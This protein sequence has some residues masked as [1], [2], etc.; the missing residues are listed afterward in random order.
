MNC[1]MSIELDHWIEGSTPLLINV[2]HAGTHIPPAIAE[3]MNADA[4]RVPDTD[5]HVDTLYDFAASLGAS[6]MVATH[7]RYVVDLNRDPQGTALYPG[8]DNSE[9]VPLR[10]FDCEPIYRE[11]KAPD[12]DE[13]ARRR[14]V[15]WQPY[16][17]RLR[18]RIDDLRARHGH[19]VLLDA[20]SIRSQVPR[21]FD[22]KLPDLNLG[23]DS[24]LS[25]AARLAGRAMDVLSDTTLF[26]A[27][28]DGRFKGGYITR[29]YADPAGGVHCL[30]LEI[31]QAAYMN[32]DPPWAWSA[33]RAS[34]LQ[35]LLI[36]LIETLVQWRP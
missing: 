27:I 9:L 8:A 30:Q 4:L 14:E 32:E 18:Q 20:H 33:Q 29:H 1:G 13:V 7:S 15:Y 28:R 10:R 23:S 34:R 5:W 22:G 17:A 3:A 25:C 19:V 16:H 36:R 35:L 31:A 11:G 21:F 26:S 6:L 24:G 12:A 2:P